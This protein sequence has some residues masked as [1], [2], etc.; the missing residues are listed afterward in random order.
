MGVQVRAFFEQA[1]GC[2]LDP[3]LIAGVQLGGVVIGGKEANTAGQGILADIA[4]CLECGGVTV[5]T[6]L[7]P[8]ISPTGLNQ[9]ETSQNENQ[10][11]NRQNLFMFGSNQ[12]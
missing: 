11:K 5:S 12:P 9:D 7:F 6:I 8:L 10:D 1:H 4:R 2:F 3:S